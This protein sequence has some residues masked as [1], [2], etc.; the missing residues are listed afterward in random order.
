MK[1]ITV[2]LTKEQRE[3]LQP[4]SATLTRLGPDCLTV[5][6]VFFMLDGSAKLVIGA[7]P[8][9]NAATIIRA[10]VDEFAVDLIPRTGD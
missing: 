5:G 6:Q 8:P 10:A 7:V 1:A 4:L 2:K 3:W 9:G